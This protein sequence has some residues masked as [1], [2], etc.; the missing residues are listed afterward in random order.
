MRL[1][2][3]ANTILKILSLG[4]IQIIRDTFFGTFLTPPSPRDMLCHFCGPS[5]PL[6]RDI[7]FLLENIL[8]RAQNR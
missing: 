3:E 6:W 2:A 4:V 8:N 5:P 7:L 1:V